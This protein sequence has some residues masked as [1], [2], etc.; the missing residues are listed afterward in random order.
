MRGRAR[1]VLTAVSLAAFLVFGSFS[2]VSANVPLVN[3]PMN[4]ENQVFIDGVRL[5]NVTVINDRTYIQLRELVD[6]TNLQ[7]ILDEQ[8]Q[9][10]N[11]FSSDAPPDISREAILF[12]ALIEITADRSVITKT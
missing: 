2:G 7:L 10:V 9:L 12:P 8:R 3:R 4:R 1:K 6:R 5:D 11:V